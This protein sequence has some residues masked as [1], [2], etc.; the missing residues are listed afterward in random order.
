MLIIPKL[1]NLIKTGKKSENSVTIYFFVF[2]INVE[3][4]DGSS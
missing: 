2:I 1:E 3:M 4:P